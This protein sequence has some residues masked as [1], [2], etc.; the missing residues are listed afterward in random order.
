MLTP[1]IRVAARSFE[2]GGGIEGVIT[3]TLITFKAATGNLGHLN[4]LRG[5]RR[6]QMTTVELT[7]F[8]GCG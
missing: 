5:L 7:G 4:S 3:Q 6:V 8:G 1:V 2:A